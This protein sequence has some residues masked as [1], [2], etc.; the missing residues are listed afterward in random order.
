LLDTGALV[1]SILKFA[2]RPAPLRPHPSGLRCVELLNKVTLTGGSGVTEQAGHGR[3]PAELILA[4]RCD[5]PGG[6][7]ET[8]MCAAGMDIVNAECWM[9]GTESVGE[10]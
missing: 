1:G 10:L 7:G 4:G 6:S 2:R 5:A 3:N 9:L 8:R